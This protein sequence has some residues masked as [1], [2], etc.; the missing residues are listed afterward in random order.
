MGKDEKKGDAM[1]E[2]E[3]KM[4]HFSAN[5]PRCKPHKARPVIGFDGTHFI[6]C[7]QGCTM[8]DAENLALEPI[9]QRWEDENK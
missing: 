7:G 9:M 2:T 8:H 4:N 5:A 1:T 3:R 6:E